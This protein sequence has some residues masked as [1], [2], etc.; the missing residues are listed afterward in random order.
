MLAKSSLNST[1]MKNFPALLLFPLAFTA[2]LCAEDAKPT[3][4]PGADWGSNTDYTTLRMN[5]ASTP[6]YNAYLY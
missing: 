2:T 4:L 6:D 5:Y 3:P 1:N